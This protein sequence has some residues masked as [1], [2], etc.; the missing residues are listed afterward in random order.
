MS[1]TGFLLV[2]LSATLT[3][4]ANLLLRSG[5][6]AAGGFAFSGLTGAAIATLRLFMQPA[7]ATGFVLYFVAAVVWFRI[8]ATE[9]LSLAYPLLVSLTFASV[10]AGAVV[11]FGEPISWRKVAGLA[12]ILLGILVISQEKSPL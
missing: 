5:I 7:F 8:V 2:L 4:A 10:T 1:S 12:L 3:M 11:L 6:D 9:P